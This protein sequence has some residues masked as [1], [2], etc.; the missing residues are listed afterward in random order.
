[1]QG[2]M[3]LRRPETA[4]KYRMAATEFLTTVQNLQKRWLGLSPRRSALEPS[5]LS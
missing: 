5:Q 4:V 3:N 2:P 1:M